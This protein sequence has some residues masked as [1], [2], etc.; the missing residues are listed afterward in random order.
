MFNLQEQVLLAQDRDEP[1]IIENELHVEEL[2][3]QDVTQALE[4]TRR[5]RPMGPASTALTLLGLLQTRATVSDAIDAVAASSEAIL[6][7]RVFDVFQSLLKYG[8]LALLKTDRALLIALLLKDSSR[9]CL[10]APSPSCW[11]P[12]PPVSHASLKRAVNAD[13]TRFLFVRS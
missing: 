4:R 3:E 1:F 9:P 11:T 7:A 5:A 10:S 2:S 13:L 6:D 8:P 12:S